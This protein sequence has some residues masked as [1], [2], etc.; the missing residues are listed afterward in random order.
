MPLT[1]FAENLLES[2]ASVGVSPDVRAD[3]LARLYDRDQ[4]A[5][6][7]ALGVGVWSLADSFPLSMAVG[8]PPQIDFPIDHGVAKPMSYW[9]V[10]NTNITGVVASLYGGNTNPPGTLLDSV[11]LTG[12]I[13]ARIF[14]LVSLRYSLVRV[15]AMSGVAPA[16]GELMLGVPDVVIGP[17]SKSGGE[18]MVGNV[19]RDRTPF[20]YPRTTKLGPARERLD[21]EW[22]GVGR[23]QDRATLRKV[24]RTCDEG[25]KSLLVRDPFNVD[26]WMQIT[27]AE[28][29][30]KV[31]NGRLSTAALTLEEVPV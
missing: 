2:A 9:A 29:A 3:L 24:Y 30:G 19:A 23:D 17:T 12:G 1:F 28:L 10:V 7:D 20:G 14:P 18:A 26:R 13:M 16:L 25:A 8:V 22:A 5:Q 4:S 27:S 11:T 31:I 15:L 6:W 21:Y